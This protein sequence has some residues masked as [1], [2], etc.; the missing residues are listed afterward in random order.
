MNVVKFKDNPIID[1]IYAILQSSPSGISEYALLSCLQEDESITIFRDDFFTVADASV[2]LFRKHFL[3][4][5]ALY[6]LQTKLINEGQCLLV[7]PL[8]I[9]LVPI[10][11]S[12][13]TN[14]SKE[15]V[16][17]KLRNYYLDLS[18]IDQTEKAEVDGMLDGFW[19]RYVANDKR[20]GALQTLGLS[21]D[22]D[23]DEVKQTYRRL[24]SEHH[25][26]KG[27]DSTQFTAIRQAYET[28]L[29]SGIK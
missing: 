2:V 20:Y 25:P 6:Q 19:Q 29:Q 14:L 1:S 12:D 10:N 7:S 9:R 21:P 15:N 23:L 13:E 16:G 11:D 5:N 28:L 22:A 24:V 17:Q 4:M 26:D 8:N 18:H 3:I 27:G